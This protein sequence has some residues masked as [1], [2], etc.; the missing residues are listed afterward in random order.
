MMAMDQSLFLI[1]FNFFAEKSII[2]FS[3]IKILY[4]IF[5]KHLF[6]FLNIED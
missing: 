6:L 1:G 5:L 3:L 2:E 4:P